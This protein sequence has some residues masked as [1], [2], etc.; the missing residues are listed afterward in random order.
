MEATVILWQGLR[1][2]LILGMKI[3]VSSN[4]LQEH[5][6]LKIWSQLID[7]SNVYQVHINQKKGL[8]NVKNASKALFKLH[9]VNRNATHALLVDIV[10]LLMKTLVILL[11][12]QQGYLTTKSIKLL[13]NLV[14]HVQRVLPV[15]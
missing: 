5:M 1:V 7:I 13:Q 15:S 10:N 14:M 2:T 3:A 9:E 11:P 6:Q 4:A 8:A 12:V